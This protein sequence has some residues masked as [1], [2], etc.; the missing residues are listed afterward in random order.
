[1]GLKTTILPLLVSSLLVVA[2][3]ILL[4]KLYRKY[5]RE[6][7]TARLKYNTN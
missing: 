4:I 5:D 2:V 1:M 6:I 3:G 7:E